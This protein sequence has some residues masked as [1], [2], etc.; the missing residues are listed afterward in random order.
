MLNEFEPE[1]YADKKMKEKVEKILSKKKRESIG[2][3]G[4][5]I[6]KMINKI[7]KEKEKIGQADDFDCMEVAKQVVLRMNC[8]LLNNLDEMEKDLNEIANK[9]GLEDSYHSDQ[10]ESPIRNILESDLI[11]N[12]KKIFLDGAKSEGKANFQNLNLNINNINISKHL[13]SPVNILLNEGSYSGIDIARKGRG[14]EKSDKIKKGKNDQRQKSCDHQKLK[15]NREN[16]IKAVDKNLKEIKF[17]SNVPLNTY[18]YAA[19]IDNSFKKEETLNVTPL[20]TR[21]KSSPKNSIKNGNSTKINIVS[22]LE[23]IED[24]DGDKISNHNNNK[25]TNNETIIEE[26]VLFDKNETKKLENKHDIFSNHYLNVDK[27]QI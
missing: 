9:K 18:S 21:K 6:L 7:S 2:N 1:T 22:P 24:V 23:I 12:Q 27:D 8:N 11:I 3:K 5:N 4:N 26:S 17:D 13:A 14:L 15:V 20:A 19:G 16:L 10:S 25:Y